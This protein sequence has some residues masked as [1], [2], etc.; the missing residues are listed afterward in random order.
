MFIF[1]IG[2]GYLEKGMMILGTMEKRTAEKPSIIFF[3]FSF[4]ESVFI[5]TRYGQSSVT[6]FHNFCPVA[7][8][9]RYVA[10]VIGVDNVY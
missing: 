3:S 2:K 7:L 10:V 4:L 9:A 8:K 6:R 5:E 1:Q